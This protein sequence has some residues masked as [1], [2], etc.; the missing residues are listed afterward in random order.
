MR[1]ARHAM[2]TRFEVALAGGRPEALR[3]A[4]EEALDEID[5]LE[6][7][8]SIYRPNSVLSRLNREAASGAVPVDPVVWGLLRHA[9][10]LSALT[11]GAFDPTAGP[12]VRAWGFHGASGAAPDPQVLA[13]AREVVGWQLVELDP[14][15]FTVRFHRPG[16]L[17]DLGAVGKGFALDRAVEILREAGIE[18]GLVHGGTSTVCA[19][20]SGPGGEGWPVAL[21]VPSGEDGP[22]EVVR[23]RDETLSVSAVWGR[24]FVAEGRMLGHVIDPRTGEPVMAASMAAVRLPSATESDALSTALLVLGEAG[25]TRL[26][27]LRAGI[28]LWLR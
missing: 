10:D 11:D 28:G 22:G 21:P 18:S 17:L 16:V 2:A 4:A 3:A 1:V 15:R 27:A 14:D 5:R 26:E 20:G 12:L 24:A 23:L 9:L 25:R 6:D 19:L 13:A 8:L 7:L